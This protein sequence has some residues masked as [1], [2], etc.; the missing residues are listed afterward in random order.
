MVKI[1]EIV[2]Q[3][4]WWQNGIEFVRYDK[5]L[6]EAKPVFFERKKIGLK[7][8]EIY[9]LRGPRQVG[10]TT[11]LKET[12]K[13]LIEKGTPQRHILYL[14]VDLFTSLREMRNALN[15]FLDS[16]R[17]APIFYLFLD[18]I[19]SIENWNLELKRLSDQGITRRGVIVA[20]GSSAVKLKEKAELLPGRGIEGNEY[21]IKPLSFREFA[22]QSIEYIISFLPRDGFSDGFGRLKDILVKSY[23]ELAWESKKIWEVFDQCLPFKE[24]IAHLFRIYLMTGGLPKV[25]NHY[26]LNLYPNG[27]EVIKPFI[28]EIFIR[29]VLGDMARLHRQEVVTRQLLASIIERYGSRYSFTRISKGIEKTH[30]TIIDYL[31]Y[32]EESF[33]CF[34]LY[35][36]DFN[37]KR[38][39]WKGD[40]KIYFFDPFILYSINSYLKGDEVW[41]I[42][43]R[44]MEDEELQG[45]L[46]EGLVISHLLMY[47]EIPFL[48]IGKT[49]L[50]FYYDKSGKE[51][52]AIFKEDSNYTAIE[53]KYQTDVRAK[54]RKGLEFVKKYIVLS[55]EDVGERDNMIIPVDIFLSLLK[56]S[57]RNI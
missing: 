18:E 26:L 44:T 9:I 14:S 46:I 42:V 35:A 16:T 13:S 39:K 53:V 24:Q 22:L 19:T 10:K 27:K 41:S 51:I 38:P 36:Y 33:I 29:D 3:N 6:Q 7:K 2:R 34:V 37:K 31:E 4:P 8:G 1:I 12:I 30:I 50:W 47:K 32:L 20:T 15:Y 40:K 11:Y 23:I 43:T 49:F 21:L 48:R 56:T 5:H 28:S 57:E 54:R 52:D 55:K 17:N 25:I 45:K